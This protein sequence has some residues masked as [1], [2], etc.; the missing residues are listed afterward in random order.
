MGGTILAEF[1][2]KHKFASWYVT[3]CSFQL[4][5]ICGLRLEMRIFLNIKVL[6]SICKFTQFS[7]NL[8]MHLSYNR[9][10][11]YRSSYPFVFNTAY[12]NRLCSA[13][14]ASFTHRRAWAE[15]LHWACRLVLRERGLRLSIILSR[16]SLTL[17]QQRQ[18]PLRHRAVRRI[19]EDA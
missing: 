4:Q 17:L 19:P 16:L 14:G 11:L 5:H 7:T 18:R 1:N 3:N 8:S 2:K 6:D 15:L 13:C 9:K 12:L 10:L